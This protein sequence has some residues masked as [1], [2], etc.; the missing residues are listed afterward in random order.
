[1]PPMAVRAEDA[2]PHA[3]AV[4]QV[5]SNENLVALIA[6]MAAC[7]Q[8]CCAMEGVSS[9]W[10]HALSD[11][12]D[13]WKKLALRDFPRLRKVMVNSACTYREQY[14]RQHLAT[15]AP[16]ADEDTIGDLSCF[17]CTIEWLAINPASRRRQL[18]CTTTSRLNFDDR[19]NLVPT[20]PAFS[21]ETIFQSPMNDAE[22][23]KQ[24]AKGAKIF[25]GMKLGLDIY[26]SF[27][28]DTQRLYR[29]V[30]E[31]FVDDDNLSFGASPLRGEKGTLQ[32][33][34]EAD[35]GRLR[36]HF[37]TLERNDFVPS[38]ELHMN[39][40]WFYL[41]RGLPWR[42]PVV[43]AEVSELIPRDEQAPTPADLAP[44]SKRACKMGHKKK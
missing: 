1:M 11:A 3:T 44:P 15:Y 32:P 39:D 27:Q 8:A 33:F 20:V 35:T 14:R 25:D 18:L 12:D 9:D 2:V 4:A 36:L 42:F 24:L 30:G 5:S 21:D 10:R 6:W 22:G 16:P 37:M 23:L 17:Q 26:L 13:L 28:S 29:G 43:K 38:V 31:Y 40:I 41:E 19:A 34:L 7:P